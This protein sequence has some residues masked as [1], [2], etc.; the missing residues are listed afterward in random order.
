MKILVIGSVNIDIVGVGTSSLIPH[1]SNIGRVDLVVGG[2][3]KNIA[4][5]LK[6]LQLDPSFLT[7]LGKDAFTKIITDYLDRIGLN[8]DHSL[9]MDGPSPK[10]LAIHHPNGALES[11]INDLMVVENVEVSAMEAEKDYIESFDTLVLDANLSPKMIDYL[12]TNFSHKTIIADGVTQSKVIRFR[13]YLDKIHL[14][15]VNANE[16]AS[17]VGEPADDV[18]NNVRLVLEKGVHQVVAT[19]GAKPITYNVDQTIFQTPIQK[20]KMMRSSVGCG[21]A[22]LAAT[23]YGLSKGL[24][25]H[26]AIQYGKKAA[27]LTMEVYSPCNP[28]LCPELLEE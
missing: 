24:N 10:Y 3:G 5:N 13:D 2:V 20:A 1:D 25:L 11:A 28:D 18:K 16:L 21:D 19:N 7:F 15:K 12:F 14:L 23:V 17:L 26:E 8:Y 4:E 27:A 9:W 6:R 22:L